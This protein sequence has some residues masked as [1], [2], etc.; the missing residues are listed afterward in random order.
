MKTYDVVVLGAGSAGESV[1]TKLAAAGRSVALV[2]ALRVGGECPYVAC[3]PSKAVLRSAQARHDASRLSDLG[4]AST[5][6][7]LDDPVAAFR[8]A[9]ERRDE[10]AEHRDDSS[11]AQGLTD[12]GVT[13]VRGHGRVT[14]A[15]VL[16]VDG[17]DLGWSE[18]VVATGSTPVRP[19]IEG[20][21]GIPTWT[22]DEALSSADRPQSL[23]V[24]GGGAVGC[25]LAQVYARFETVVTLVQS[26][27]SL[28][29]KEESSVADG[30]AQILRDDGV[31]VGVGVTVERCERVDGGAWLHLSDGTQLE[32]ERVL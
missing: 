29:P 20:L 32:V 22:S 17:R 27:K 28:A 6:L 16:A 31:D 10:V 18:L 19:D 15:G 2:E 24:M 30:L 23:L 13:V 21:D 5:V 11:A 4:G 26:A 3:M 7:G 14:R 9:A 1:A 25:E 8:R 12:A